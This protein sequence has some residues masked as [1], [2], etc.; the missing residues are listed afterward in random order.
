ME[1]DRRGVC[2]GARATAVRAC[3]GVLRASLVGFPL[4]HRGS[5]LSFSSV[6][7]WGVACHTGVISKVI[8]VVGYARIEM[9][10]HQRP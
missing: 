4:N 7:W 6:L 3:R 1:V 8:L 9:S 10:E 5:S 2:G